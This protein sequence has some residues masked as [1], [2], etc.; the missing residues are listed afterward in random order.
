[1]VISTFRFYRVLEGPYKVSYSYGLQGVLLQG[2]MEVF[3]DVF[4]GLM[5][6]RHYAVIRLFRV[7]RTVLWRSCTSF[8]EGRAIP[9]SSFSTSS[10]WS[11]G[12]TSPNSL[13]VRV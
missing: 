13:M 1:M 5:D 8:D 4:Q 6:V 11:K 9:V 10:F 2:F 12:D 7:S 3:H